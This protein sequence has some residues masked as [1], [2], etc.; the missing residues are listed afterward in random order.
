MIVCQLDP[1]GNILDRLILRGIHHSVDSLILE[2][3]IE[4][5]RPRIV[6]A[7][8][9]TS[10]RGANPVT[11]EVIQESLRRVLTPPVGVKDRHTLLDRAPPDR[12][13]NGLTHQGRVH[14]VGHRVTHDLLGAAVQNGRKIDKPGPRL[15]VGNVP[16]PLTSR[17]VGGSPA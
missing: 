9:R 8:P 17:F 14:V 16:A 12:H 4:R 7:H 13:V 6:P 10:H 2:R 11:L 1:R 15:D 5:L 3:G